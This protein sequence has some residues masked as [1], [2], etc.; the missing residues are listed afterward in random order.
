[1]DILITPEDI[2]KRCLYTKYKRF[3]L[4]NKK[5]E[6]IDNI[7]KE[8]ELQIISEEDAYVI[9]LLKVVETENLIHRFRL[10]IEEFIKNKST[11]QEEKVII[12]KSA[13]IKEVL[14]FNDRFPDAYKPDF[15]YQLSINELKEYVL[16]VAAEIEKLQ[17]I[18]IPFKEKIFTYVQSKFVNKIVKWNKLN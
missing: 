10:D 1:M 14:E 3:V 6:E 13:L 2:I 16:N 11:I 4:K 17:I 18:Q 8:N 15:V 12:S 9:G 7:I 5:K